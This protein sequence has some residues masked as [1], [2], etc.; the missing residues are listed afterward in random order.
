MQRRG[1]TL[2]ELLVVISIIALLIGILLPALSAA[3]DTARR[4]KNNSNVRSTLQ[5][6]TIF[7]NDHDHEYP[8]VNIP[9]A[10]SYPE[11][12]TFDA[13]SPNARALPLV[14]GDYVAP[15]ILVNPA[16]PQGAPAD[17][18]HIQNAQ[19]DARGGTEWV[20]NLDDPD[21]DRKRFENN[22]SYAM[23][24]LNP[25]RGPA[26]YSHPHPEWQD[27]TAASAAL[28][29][30]RTLDGVEDPGAGSVWDRNKWQGSVGWGDVHVDYDS[31]SMVEQTKVGRS[32][33][34]NDDNNTKDNLDNLFSTD[35]FR[36]VDDENDEAK[37]NDPAS[38]DDIAMIDPLSGSGEINNTFEGVSHSET[39][40]N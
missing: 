29:A 13:A 38:T 21:E 1:F 39:G 2:I 5:A 10:D 20:G 22:L 14:F 19:E 40:G 16:D 31:D 4:M 36:R 35:E 37:T 26:P 25:E 33:V 17:S 3:R 6:M 23:L 18:E 7:A 8:N 30:D 32:Y 28:I 34:V 15:D 12:R 27:K 24:F 9:D 11:S